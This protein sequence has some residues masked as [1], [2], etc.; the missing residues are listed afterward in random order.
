MVLGITEFDKKF[1]IP[2]ASSYADSHRQNYDP[3][4][5]DRAQRVWGFYLIKN[6]HE[7]VK[8]SQTGGNFVCVKA[9]RSSL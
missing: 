5:N 2:H 3:D 4:D 7:R 9:K 1:V 6:P 8:A